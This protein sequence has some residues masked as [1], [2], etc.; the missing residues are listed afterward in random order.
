MSRFPIFGDGA[1][2][3]SFI[4]IDDAA[5]ATPLAIGCGPAGIFNI[6]D[7]EPAE[8]SVWLPELARAIGAKPPYRLPAWLGRMA[9][10][11]AGMSMMTNAIG[12]VHATR[13]GDEDGVRDALE[14]GL[15]LADASL[16]GIL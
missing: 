1:G 11:D 10:G 9:I 16:R 2:V 14:N 3:S 7:D 5:R 4:H 15:K 8:V 6:V 12:T 13:V